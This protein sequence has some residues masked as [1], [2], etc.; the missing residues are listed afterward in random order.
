[1]SVPVIAFFN[2][3]GGVGKTSLVYHLAWMY[4]DMGYR[5]VAADFDP[6][7][8]LTAAF[9]DEERLEQL[10]EGEGSENTVYGSVRPLLERAGDIKQPH[11]EA[12]RP[13]DIKN[14]QLEFI[15]DNLGLLAGDLAL[16]KCEDMLSENWPKCLTGDV[17]AFRVLSAFWRIVQMAAQAHRAQLILMDLGPNLGAINRAALISSDN[18]VIPLSP[19]LFSLQGLRNLGPTLRE[20]REDWKERLKKVPKHIGFEL[21]LGLIQP[22]GY[23]VMQH[24]LRLDRPAVFYGRWIEKIPD[25]YR[26]SVL[27]Q[28]MSLE[29]SKD[30]YRLA[31]LKHY[32][33]LMPMAQEARKPIFH[34]KSADGAI[35]SHSV[36]ARDAG[37]DF[38]LLAIDILKRSGVSDTIVE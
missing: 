22:I 34:L 33:S 30:E 37:R 10:W 8:N 6:Q 35:G 15:N 16:T 26:H 23:I 29:E 14:P 21:P 11:L 20:W 5:I 36:A 12:I 9:L 7:A 13:N 18:V 2:N 3:K 32:R 24:S 25:E 19:D 27:A 38:E 31:L 28:D 17:G 4:S 1:V